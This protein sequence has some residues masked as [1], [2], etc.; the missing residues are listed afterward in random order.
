V[1]VGNGGRFAR[2]VAEKL[3][4]SVRAVSQFGTAII[5]TPAGV[6][7]IV[8]ARSET[9]SSPAALPDIKPSSIEDDLARRDFSVNAMALSVMPGK[10][11]TMLDPHHGFGDCARKKVR[12]LHEK[13]FQDDPTR[14]FRAV[15]YEVRLGFKIEV[16]TSE[17]LERDLMMIDRLSGARALAELR[18]MLHEPRRAEIFERAEQVGL[19]EAVSPALRVS[20]TG[21]E[22]MRKM[23][24]GVDELLYVACMTAALT[25]DEGDALCA[26]LEP[27]NEWR[28]VIAGADK[29]RETAA[30]LDMPNISPSEIV[31]LLSPIPVPV[32][33]VVRLT[34]PKTRKEHVESYLRRY[35]DVRPELTGQELMA[36]GVPEGPAVGKL[37]EE[38]KTGRLDGKLMSRGDEL[39]HVKR[40]LPSLLSRTDR[41]TGA[42]V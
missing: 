9:Y 2:A 11:G 32:L 1:V 29:Y 3:K 24:D 35:R 19:L 4:G 14:I 7:D 42:A 16:E 34:A 22:A 30:V 10:W 15:R 39:A 26:R 25:K 20:E 38:L 5:D 28:A 18:K 33:E 41:P 40:R 27:D 21:L 17:W 37:L 6:M 36:E 13:S 8:T 23:G 12:V 31:E